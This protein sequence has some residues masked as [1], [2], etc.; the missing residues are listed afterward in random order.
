MIKTTKLKNGAVRLKTTRYLLEICL[1]DVLVY[2]EVKGTHQKYLFFPG[3]A[4]NPA[5]KR[6]ETKGFEPVKV[7]SK[8][9]L[10]VL[11]F[12]EQSNLWKN[13]RHTWICREDSI[14]VFYDLKGRGDV[15]RAHYFRG[16]F[17]GEERGMGGEIDEVFSTCPNFQEKLFFHPGES[18]NLSAGNELELPVGGQALA[19]P[20]YCLGLHDRRDKAFWSVGLAAIPGKY[21]WDS[22]Q[23]NPSALI[24][25]TTYKGDSVV[26]GGFAAVYDGKLKVEGAWQSPRLVMTFARDRYD[27]LRQYLEYCY[28]QGYLL[29]PPRRKPVD[30]WLEP[31]Y[32]TWHDQIAR[33][34]LS[35]KDPLGLRAFDFCTQELTDRWVRLLEK[36]RCKPGIVVLD[37]T[38]AVN[39]NSGEPDRKKW[40][41]MRGWIEQCH[42]RGIRVFVWNCSW[43]VEGVPPE[44]CIT[45][46]GK[47]VVCDIT[48]PK[49]LR[50]F[51]EMIR[52]WFSDESG[53]LNADGVKVDGQLSLP[54]GPGL[55]SYGSIWGLELQRFYLK[56][57]YEEA[58]KYKPDACIDSFTLNPLLAEYV[59]MVRIADMYT[60]RLTAHETML[61]RANLYRIALPQA[62]IDTDGQIAH[63]T[64]NDYNRELAEQAKL[65][66]PCLYTAELLYRKRFFL[67]L[68]ITKMTKKDYQT[69]AKVF[70][71]Y[72]QK[73][74]AIR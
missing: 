18:F 73:L 64:L 40:P 39:L 61:H 31:I 51:R 19:S 46:D 59:D 20:C 4:C 48:N 13:K 21:T 17:S 45:R 60:N 7:I 32:C 37:A 67:P 9:D 70:A 54:T 43:A 33:A 53:C 26:G 65:G 68:R 23:W 16:Y 14:E 5:G 36:N 28:R 56:T 15:E 44:E 22:L 63:Y 11:T 2:L 24:P 55:R 52:R 58:R 41:D 35:E 3:G 71:E 29:C 30:W 12:R 8:S 74:A 62:V 25:P 34:A 42:K 47:P 50:R 49:Y 6:D 69:F 10:T 57:L 27:V 72:R 38:W 66:I 1:R